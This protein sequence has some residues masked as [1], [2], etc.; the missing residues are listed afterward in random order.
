MKFEFVTHGEFV[1]LKRKP[2]WLSCERVR[3]NTSVR[4]NQRH[5][6]AW[7]NNNSRELIEKESIVFFNVP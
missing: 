6:D 1:I 2:K 3:S 5:T 7:A 4:L